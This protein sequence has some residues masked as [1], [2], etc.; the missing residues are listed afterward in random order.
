MQI[1]SCCKRGTKRTKITLFM[2]IS[3]TSTSYLKVTITVPVVAC[4]CISS[5]TVTTMAQVTVHTNM[6]TATIVE[7]T[8]IF[9][10]KP[11]SNRPQ[12]KAN[13]SSDRFTGATQTQMLEHRDTRAFE[14]H[15]CSTM[16]EKVSFLLKRSSSESL[17]SALEGNTDT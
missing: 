4:N 2:H 15:S 14:K 7:S 13:I 9:I 16:V 11:N 6:F 1:T 5:T 12:Y 3:W 10:C 17:A 8:F